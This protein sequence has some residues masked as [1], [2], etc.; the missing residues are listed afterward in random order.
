MPIY[1]YKC[2]DCGNLYELLLPRM[3]EKP[4]PCPKCTSANTE[5]L[6]SAIGG[7]S[8]GGGG[9]PSCASGGGCPGASSCRAAGG[10]CPSFA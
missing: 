10:G 1:E 5:K 8:M 4:R 6:M 7:I 9:E 3:E 2:N